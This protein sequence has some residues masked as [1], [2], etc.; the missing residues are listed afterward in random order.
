MIACSSCATRNDS[1]PAIFVGKNRTQKPAGLENLRLFDRLSQIAHRN[2]AQRTEHLDAP[3]YS[4][5]GEREAK[6]K[7]LQSCR[8]ARRLKLGLSPL[9]DA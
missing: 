3:L 9:L 7:L 1:V 8:G 5:P 2:F 6:K 4:A